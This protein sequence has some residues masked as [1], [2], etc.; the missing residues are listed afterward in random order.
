M[1]R[2]SF[3]N[4]LIF[5]NKFFEI[6]ICFNDFGTITRTTTYWFNDKFF[7]NFFNFN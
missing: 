2:N 4:S 1:T 5:L 7:K 3:L 6:F